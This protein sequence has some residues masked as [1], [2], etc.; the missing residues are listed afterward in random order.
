LAYLSGNTAVVIALIVVSI[1]MAPLAMSL[2]GSL[3]RRERRR[4]IERLA[5]QPEPPPMTAGSLTPDEEALA[6]GRWRWNEPL[7]SW[8]CCEHRGAACMLCRPKVSQ[9]DGDAANLGG[10]E[11][12]VSN[13]R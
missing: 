4:E 10:R 12:R 6:R 5:A 8:I 7:R 11:P 13:G 3:A 1:F 9:P 2:D